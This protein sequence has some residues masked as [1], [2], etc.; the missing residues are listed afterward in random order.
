[1]T[2]IKI[3]DP[4]RFPGRVR[5]TDRHTLPAD[6]LAISAAPGQDCIHNQ[7]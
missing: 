6:G 1:M 5:K 2:D 4:A 7:A 3:E